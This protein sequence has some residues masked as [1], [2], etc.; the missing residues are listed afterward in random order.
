MTEKK[1]LGIFGTLN[2]ENLKE[3]KEIAQVNLRHEN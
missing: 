2:D 1:R 3:V